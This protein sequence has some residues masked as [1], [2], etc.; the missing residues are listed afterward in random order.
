MHTVTSK[1][2]TKIAYD[3]FGKGPVVILV[4]GALNSRKTGVKLAK[5]LA[6][7]YTAVT[8]DRRGRGNSTDSLPYSP[9]REIEDLAALIDGVGAPVYLYGHS[10]GAA[11]ALETTKK[12]PK[13]IK[14]LAI[15][16]APYSTTKEEI[17]DSKDYNKQVKKLLAAGDKGGAVTLF[18]S[19]VG[20]SE[21]QIA[22][23]KRL[24]MWKGLEAL[25]PTLAYDSDV[26]GEGHA[27]RAAHLAGIT[28]PTLVMHGGK[29]APMMHE[30]AEAISKAM[31]KARLLTVE[32]EDHGV[33]PK[34]LT[35]I[36]IEFFK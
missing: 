36:L 34:A 9:E 12:L 35:P 18:V 32:G 24:P 16:E 23:M 11:L 27:M 10:S 26:M 2:G 19:N 8:Y 1:D 13:N 20:V 15:Y 31:P 21:K 14:K 25:A 30:A 4:L 28:T 29:G 17:K 7:H 5:T 3:M 22:A 6:P 33:S